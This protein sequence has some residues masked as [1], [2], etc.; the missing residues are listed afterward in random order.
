MVAP[1]ALRSGGRH[2]YSRPDR[3]RARAT[4]GDGMLTD[5]GARP[6]DHHRRRSRA[7]ARALPDRPAVAIRNR[8]RNPRRTPCS[9]TPAVTGKAT[10]IERTSYSLDERGLQPMSD[11]LIFRF[12]DED[13]GPWDSDAID[14]P[15][16]PV[17]TRS[18]HGN[19]GARCSRRANDRGRSAH[20]RTRHRSDASIPSRTD[21]RVPDPRAGSF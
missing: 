18:H 14:S 5:A 1:T 19:Q 4:E 16:S 2:I 17:D 6:H 7:G 11:L 10:D 8:R 15:A 12:C 21:R 13:P 3:R 9:S 20:P